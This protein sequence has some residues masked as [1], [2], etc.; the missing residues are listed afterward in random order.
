[1]PSAQI[2]Q[3]AIFE[4]GSAVFMARMVSIASVNV[5]QAS[6][7]TIAFDFFDTVTGLSV[8]SGPL[9]AASVIFDTLQTDARWTKDA[10]GY[11]FRHTTGPSQFPDGGKV[12]RCEWKFTDT[13]GAVSW[14]VFDVP[15]IALR[16]S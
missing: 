7:A 9:S 2:F 1:M 16:T 6:I 15:T 8:A 11:N 3:A 10:I 14:L 4:D 5:T 12:Y 13:G